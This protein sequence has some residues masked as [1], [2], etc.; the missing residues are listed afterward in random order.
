MSFW[1]IDGK[2][3][4]SLILMLDT[5]RRGRVVHDCV[6]CADFKSI[7]SR[8]ACDWEED[9]PGGRVKG[10]SVYKAPQSRSSQV[11]TQN[12]LET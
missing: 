10:E 4:P 2:G 7:R 3:S 12:H 6:S 11:M 8:D 5:S 1:G 9:G